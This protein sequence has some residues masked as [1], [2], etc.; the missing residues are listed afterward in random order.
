MHQ[1]KDKA[2]KA[3]QNGNK[4]DVFANT[5]GLLS[6]PVLMTADIMLY[7]AT[8]IISLLFSID[9][10][11]GEDQIQHCEIA[12][13]I[14]DHFNKQYNVNFNLPQ[15]EVFESSRIMSLSD[16]TKKMSKSSQSQY[17]NITIIGTAFF[18]DIITRS[19]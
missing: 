15:P 18:I 5:L 9:I 17:S 11:V 16:G 8:R 6:Y 4:N 3:A 2:A 14:I 12:R 10:P 1:F 19:S 7:N 13:D